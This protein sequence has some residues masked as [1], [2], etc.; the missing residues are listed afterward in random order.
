MWVWAINILALIGAIFKNILKHPI[1]R[2]M[3][4]LSIFFSLITWT[5]DYFLGTVK[6][7]MNLQY[8]DIIY[9]LG[10]AQALQVLISFAISTYVANHLINYFKNF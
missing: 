9:Y 10:I 1:F 7:N 4:F 8:F 2:K 3:A 6:S 5:I